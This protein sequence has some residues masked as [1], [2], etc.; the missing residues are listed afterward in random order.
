MSYRLE[1][2]VI[3]VVFRI[4]YMP[5]RMVTTATITVLLHPLNSLFS[6]TRKVKPDKIQ[7][8]QE[9]VGFCDG[10]GISWTICKTA[11]YLLLVP[12][13]KPHQHPIT[14]NFYRPD[15]LLQVRMLVHHISSYSYSSP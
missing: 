5:V 14:R 15:A 12:D 4:V 10:S 8:K 7:M 13:R 11:N 9:I 3:G 2:V 6:S 1:Y